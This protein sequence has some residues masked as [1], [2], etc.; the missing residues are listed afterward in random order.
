[1]LFE[2]RALQDNIFRKK[3]QNILIRERGKLKIRYKQHWTYF[4]LQHLVRV[5]TNKLRVYICI[6]QQI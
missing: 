4:A 2:F 5:I 6:M 1:M 3:Y